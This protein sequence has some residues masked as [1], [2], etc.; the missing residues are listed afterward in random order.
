VIT[1]G[2]AG[3]FALYF[4]REVL[5]PIA[6]AVLLNAVFRPV[7]RWLERI[8]VP[9]AIGA[10][11][12]V[13]ALLGAVAGIAYGLAGPVKEWVRQ[14]PERF[15]MAGQ[16]LKRVIEPVRQVSSA[17]TKLQHAAQG[18]TTGPAAAGAGP[19]EQSAPQPAPAPAPA[20]GGAAGEAA[21]RFLGTTRQVVSG[22]V[23]AVILLYLLLAAGDLFVRKLIKVIPLWRDKQRAE[24]VVEESQAAVMRYL[25]VTA[26]INAGQAVVVGLVL[27]WLGMPAPLLWA[28]L[29]FVL[30]FIPYLGATVMIALIAVVAFGAFDSV[31]RILM[32]PGSYL[33]I[34]TIQNNLVSPYLYGQHLKLNPVAVLVGVLIWWFLWGIPGAFLAVPIIATIKIVADRTEGFKPVGEF[35]GE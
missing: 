28:I 18:P 2:V 17:A 33:I 12:V 7:V 13:L 4:G 15:E 19:A 21:A 26:L 8:R 35:L 6:F 5:V 24:R 31:G 23:E 34:T 25:V 11:V 22:V 30:E 16:K 9:T 14:A 10:G 3:A 32:A 20:P 29:T 1:A 27:W